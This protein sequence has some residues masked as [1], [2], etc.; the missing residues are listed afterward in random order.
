MGAILPPKPVLPIVAAASRYATALGW[1]RDKLAERFEADVML[2]PP[3]S[4]HQ[5]DYYEA[6][7][8]RNLKKQFLVPLQ[9]VTPEQLADWKI[10]MN[11]WEDEYQAN[12]D[13]P[14]SRA[15][16][17][18]PG[19]LSEDKL[20][21]ASTKNHA[22]RIYL[23]QGIYAEITLQ[24]RAKQ[25]QACPWTYPDY[26]EEAFH[27]FFDIGRNRLRRMLREVERP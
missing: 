14:E 2:S 15:L 16:N 25:W 21:L 5:T 23:Q 17:L 19:Y 24:Y 3:F 4:F 9:L 10:E 26:R 27:A 1:A 13:G 12:H 18:D 20:V 6:T 11:A 7:M 8:G 22:H